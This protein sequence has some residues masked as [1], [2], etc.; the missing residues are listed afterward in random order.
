MKPFIRLAAAT[1]VILVAFL[2][3]RPMLVGRTL[4]APDPRG[5]ARVLVPEELRLVAPAASAGA[6]AV[7]T[8]R[9][10]VAPLRAVEDRVFELTNQERSRLKLRPLERLAGLQGIAFAHS[11]DMLVR[12]FF[13]HLNPDGLTPADRVAV[14]ER[15]LIGG[16]WENIWSGTGLDTA[17][18]EALAQMIVANWMASS[19]HRENMLRPGYTHLGVG[20][21]SS[22]DGVRAT[23]LFAET[24][25]FT[26]SPVP[27]VITRG[28]ALAFVV[29]PVSGAPC[30]G[31]ELWSSQI[32]LRVL[33]PF[34]LTGGTV[35][36]PPGIYKVRFHC[37]DAGGRTIVHPG[38]QLEVR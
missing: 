15:N 18:T 8:P 22:G 12:A 34:A 35:D 7:A 3:L 10:A 28:E 14:K 2:V 11:E 29:K 23:Q 36:A 37:P 5:R 1:V 38:P 9:G 21:A 32:G 33:G 17:K 30:S 6:A 25:G 19:S 20:V 16:A 13:D 27:S 26:G 31:F 4:T 24:E